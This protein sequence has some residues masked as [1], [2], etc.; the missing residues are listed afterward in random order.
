MTWNDSRGLVSKWC[1]RRLPTIERAKCR[2]QTSDHAFTLINI[3]EGRTVLCIS[4][5]PSLSA[6]LN[7]ED[8][9]RLTFIHVSDSVSLLA[10]SIMQANMH[11]Y[12]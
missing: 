2:C 7:G 10:T 6:K 9:P 3:C 4:K 1:C 8:F 5:H 12:Y 11:D